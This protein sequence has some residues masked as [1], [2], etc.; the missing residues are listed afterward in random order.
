MTLKEFIQNYN[1]HD[2]L[3][4]RIDYDKKAATVKLHVDFCYCQQKII[5]MKF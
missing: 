3:L 5:P 2:S 1:L 4:E